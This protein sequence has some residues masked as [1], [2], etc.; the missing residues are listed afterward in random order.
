MLSIQ[1][2]H[3]LSSFHSKWFRTNLPSFHDISGQTTFPLVKRKLKPIPRKI[4]KEINSQQDLKMFVKKGLKIKN[5]VINQEGSSSSESAKVSII[6][7]D[8]K[9][10]T[11][12]C[13]FLQSLC[14]N[15][16][17]D[18]DIRCLFKLHPKIRYLESLKVDETNLIQ[19]S[20]HKTLK[21]L[22][23]RS[24]HLQNF[25]NAPIPEIVPRKRL[26]KNQRLSFTFCLK[27]S[28]NSHNSNRV[29]RFITAL[30]V[31]SS[32]VTHVSGNNKSIVLGVIILTDKKNTKF[33]KDIKMFHHGLNRISFLSSINISD[34]LEDQIYDLLPLFNVKKLKVLTSL[35][36]TMFSRKECKKVIEK[37]LSRQGAKLEIRTSNYSWTNLV[38][39]FDLSQEMFAKFGSCFTFST[40]TFNFHAPAEVKQALINHFSTIE[41]K[42]EKL[43]FLFK[44]NSLD[45]F[46][47][48]KRTCLAEM[49]NEILKEKNKG[50]YSEINFEI[51]LN[52]NFSREIYHKITEQI[53]L[54]IQNFALGLQEKIILRVNEKVQNKR[55]L[56]LFLNN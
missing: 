28:G 33:Q 48:E 41:N 34:Q 40:F 29:Q 5:L 27:K 13:S 21:T 53:E 22:L 1:H 11:K 20:T 30:S 44:T 38:E 17:G 46:N 39:M 56:Q 36:L 3:C 4:S 7:S 6:F 24:K 19:P 35:A 32:A 37:F 15:K 14:I 47:E 2:Q 16:V 50:K 49:M 51:A 23:F 42:W 18:K 52:D 43:V 26:P 10:L 31:W 45:W 25:K 54:T 9:K 55:N 12:S 8:M